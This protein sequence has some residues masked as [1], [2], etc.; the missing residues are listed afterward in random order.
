LGSVVNTSIVAQIDFNTKE[1]RNKDTKNIRNCLAGINIWS[2]RLQKENVIPAKA[3][4]QG[5]KSDFLEI[6][7][8]P[9]F[10]GMTMI[11][12][13]LRKLHDLLDSYEHPMKTCDSGPTS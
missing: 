4:I 2:H 10:A 1:R 7:W 6:F 5:V 9:A 3:G 8:I 12:L 13:S 11:Q